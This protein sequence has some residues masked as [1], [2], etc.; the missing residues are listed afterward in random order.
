MI[1]NRSLPAFSRLRP[2]STWLRIMVPTTIV[3]A[4]LATASAGCGK[5]QGGRLA[6]YPAEGQVLWKGKPLA[7]AQVVFYPKGPADER[8]VAPRAQTDSNGHFQLGT[9]ERAD[10]APEGDYAVTVIYYA[11]RPQDGGAGPNAL[12]KKYASAKTTDL[13][14]KIAKDTSALPA[15]VL[16]DPRPANSEGISS[17][18]EVRQ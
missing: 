8:P 15:L 10:G 13:Q 16:N 2:E 12:P 14:V 5:G 3:A 17:R 9:Y 11:M 1:M 18:T 7:G 4:L 6:V